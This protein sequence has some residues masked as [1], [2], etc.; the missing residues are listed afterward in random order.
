MAGAAGPAGLV[1]LTGGRRA[2]EQRLDDFFA[3]GKLLT[4]PAGTAR[5]VWISAPYDGKPTYNRSYGL[6]GSES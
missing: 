4:D 5:E 6:S 3:Y 2:A 1:G